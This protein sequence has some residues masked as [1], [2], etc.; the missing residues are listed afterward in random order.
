[1]SIHPFAIKFQ[2]NLF[3]ATMR[4]QLSQFLVS[5]DKKVVKLNDFNR[6]EFVLWDEQKKEYCKYGEGHGNGNVSFAVELPQKMMVQR[7]NHLFVLA[8][9]I[10]FTFSKLQRCVCQN[11]KWRSPEEYFDYD[12][13]QQV[14]VFS[15]GNNMYSLLTGLWPFFSENNTEKVKERV[16]TGEKPYIDPRYKER[17]TAEA[18]LAEIIDQCHSYHPEDRPSVFEIVKFLRHA[19][20][21]V[22][23]NEH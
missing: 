5:S 18:K 10:I 16:K 14:D 7:H 19:L 20:K 12:L 6:A 21:H 11:I 15:L 13:T 22:K 9:N 4:S 3:T 2:T 17:S 23:E 8:S 1:M